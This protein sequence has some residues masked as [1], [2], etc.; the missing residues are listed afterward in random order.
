MDLTDA[1][2]QRSRSARSFRPWVDGVIDRISSEP[3]LRKAARFR[4]DLMKPL[5][6]EVRPLAHFA[7]H[8]FNKSCLV[9]LKF[10]RGN[11][12]YDGIVLWN[13]RLP[14]SSV[15]Y[16]EVTQAH[17]GE[18]QHLRMLALERDGHVSAIG[19]VHKTGTKA[20]GITVAVDSDALRHED[21][22]Q[23][24]IDR[25]IEAVERKSRKKYLQGTALVV[26]FDDSMAVRDEQDLAVVNA[27]ITEKCLPLAK[28]FCLCAFVGGTRNT[29]I[30]KSP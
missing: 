11:Q 1:D 19:K 10:V 27:V 25:I 6:E 17:E 16:I 9:R 15:R 21:V 24:E 20:S 23:A 5:F 8:H 28:Q 3:G 30:E 14:R 22:R 2:L 26:A 7:H 13:W 4:Q 18:D 29:Y 12:P